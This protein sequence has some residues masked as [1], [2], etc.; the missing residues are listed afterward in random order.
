MST[1]K[2]SYGGNGKIS[3]EL[4]RLESKNMRHLHTAEPANIDSA[5]IYV[6]EKDCSVL[7][8][9][10]FNSKN[11]ENLLKRKRVRKFL[12]EKKRFFRGEVDEVHTHAEL[13]L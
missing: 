3:F 8:C 6:S 9:E 12:K 10:S 11:K 5:A 1:I 7:L 13:L 2:T 4:K